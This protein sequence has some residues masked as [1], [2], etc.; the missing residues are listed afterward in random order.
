MIYNKLGKTD[1]L[2]SAIGLGGHEYRWLHAGNIANSRQLR[3]NPVRADVVAAAR[4]GGIN[5]YDTTYQ[6]EVQSLGHILNQTGGRNELVINGMII[7]LLK[8]I[9]GLR[10]AE[11][12]A[13]ILSELDVRLDLLGSDHFDIF[14]LCNIEMAY[15]PHL[16]MEVMEV[17]L[18]EREKGKFRFIGVSGH[19]YDRF[20]DFLSLDP[21]V[22]VVMFPY[23]YYRANEPGSSLNRLLAE[24]RDRD[25]GFIAIKPLCWSVYGVPF[26]AINAEWY[27]I[28][29]LVIEGI[30][31]A[32]VCR[33]CPDQ[34]CWC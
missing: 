7:D 34:C 31:L 22:D 14:M 28:E 29:D 15:D 4:S 8:Q 2:V 5:F 18:Q 26:T 16:A 9:N 1:L 6:E 3:Y 12:K 11:R 27:D 25:L 30:L 21:P 17:F 33:C 10:Q 24:V 13:L 19:N 23:N 32:G 20:L